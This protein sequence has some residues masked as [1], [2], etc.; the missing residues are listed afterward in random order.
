MTRTTGQRAAVP[1]QHDLALD[2]GRAEPVGG[3]GDEHEVEVG[4]QH[5][6]GCVRSGSPRVSCDHR[7]TTA[8]TSAWSAARGMATQSPTAGSS[9]AWPSRRLTVGGGHRAAGA[10]DAHHAPG[11]QVGFIDV[12]V[13]G[14]HTVVPAEW[15]QGAELR[16]GQGGLLGA[17]AL[18]PVRRGESASDR[19]RRRPR[20]AAERRSHSSGQPPLAVVV[21]LG[22]P[23]RTCVLRSAPV[24]SER[25]ST[26]GDAGAD[27]PRAARGRGRSGGRPPVPRQIAVAFTDLEGFT[28]YTSDY[29]DERAV[30][31]LDDHHFVVKQ[32]LRRHGG[33]VVK[34]LGDGLMLSFAGADSEA[35]APSPPLVERATGT[36]AAAG[37]G[38]LR[39]GRREPRRRA[40]PHGE[41]RGPRHR[42]GAWRHRAGHDRG[43]RRRRRRSTAWSSGGARRAR[44]KGVPE[45]ISVCELRRSPSARRTVE[46]TWA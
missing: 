21:S 5:L 23:D 32:V 16:V 22:R 42:A 24:S 28:Q 17:G 33:R 26:V 45:K 39:R 12:G 25:G 2:T 35:A 6:V 13:Q 19:V 10:L 34:R 43:P 3:R 40:R 4:R 46:Q 1:C 37:R 36:A 20:R 38:A 29:G 15:R 31:L 30:Q 18:R 11:R 14:G 8:I 44:L 9:A 7:G 27:R 41:H